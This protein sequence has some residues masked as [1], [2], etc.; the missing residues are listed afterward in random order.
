MKT[1]RL[2]TCALIGLLLPFSAQRALAGPYGDSLGKCLVSKTTS[3]EKA[4]LVRWMFAMMALHPEVQGSSSVTPTQREALTKETAQ[5][6]QRLLT[7]QCGTE[8]REAIKYEGMATLESSFSL[9]GQVAARELF[10]HPK[11]AEG[12]AELGQY[13]DEDKFKQLVE[14]PPQQ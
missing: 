2:A 7:E 4:T 3:V 11:V 13:L 10:S 9:L 8:A 5:L 6:F 1:F 14:A 12:L